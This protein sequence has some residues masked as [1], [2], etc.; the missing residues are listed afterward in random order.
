[1]KMEWTEEE[2][3]MKVFRRFVEDLKVKGAE[4]M[5]GL[6]MRKVNKDDGKGDGKMNKD[7]G[8]ED[9]KVNKDDGKEDGK[10]NKEAQNMFSQKP[11][12]GLKNL[13]FKMSLVFSL[14]HPNHLGQPSRWF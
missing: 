5:E 14:T 12:F 8:K 3:D 9:G 10:V 1:M 6:F 13:F 11:V 2:I 4:R 7:D